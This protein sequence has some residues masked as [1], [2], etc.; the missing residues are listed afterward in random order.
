MLLFLVSLITVAVSAV[1]AFLG[2]DQAQSSH[3]ESEATS[4]YRVQRDIAA[5][6]DRQ[7]WALYTPS[8]FNFACSA[9]AG[10]PPPGPWRRCAWTKQRAW[11]GGTQHPQKPAGGL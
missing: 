10:S 8:P 4:D 5:A 7:E 11:R 6:R 9:A 3:A 1:L 2:L